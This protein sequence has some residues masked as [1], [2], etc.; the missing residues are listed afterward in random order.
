M[1]RVWKLWGGEGCTC[2]SR[3]WC[4]CVNGGHGMLSD[5]MA[6]HSRFYHP[7]QSTQEVGSL[8]SMTTWL[9]IGMGYHT[10]ASLLLGFS[11]LARSHSWYIGLVSPHTSSCLHV[12]PP[13][14]V[15]SCSG[16][17]LFFSCRVKGF[18]SKHSSMYVVVNPLRRWAESLVLLF[19]VIACWGIATNNCS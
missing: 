8:V 4:S 3:L 6:G 17:N 1:K 15:G 10:H 7:S 2:V 12:L 11:G 13:V 19:L 18:T 5:P 16:T 14:Q 9:P